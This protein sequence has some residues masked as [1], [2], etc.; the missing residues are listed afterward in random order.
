MD[1]LMALKAAWFDYE[2]QRRAW[3]DKQKQ[4]M[5]RIAQLTH[6]RDVAA[7]AEAAAAEPE[8]IKAVK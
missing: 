5:P 6:E 3:E 8:K 2:M 4:I 7:A 1:E